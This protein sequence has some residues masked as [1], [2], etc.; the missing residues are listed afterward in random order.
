MSNTETAIAFLKECAAG[1]AK[2]AFAAHV[3][4][5]L[6]HHN[7]HFAANPDTL[8][9]AMDANARE[10]PEKTFE[11]QRSVEQGDLVM[12][13][14]R[15]RMT[16]NGEDIAVVHILRFSGDRIAELWDVATPVPPNSPNTNGAF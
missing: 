5:G 2:D 16:P 7:P 6:C 13:H 14:S 12:V 10:F 9:A 3:A 1:R 8:A 4:P 11:V 15:V